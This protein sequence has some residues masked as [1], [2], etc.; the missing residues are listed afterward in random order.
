M[1]NVAAGA[2]PLIFGDLRGYQMVRRIGFSVQVLRELYAEV[3]Q[4]ALVG[5]VRFG[6][7]VTEPWRM[8]AL[9]VSA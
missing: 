8:R 7:Q 9:K 6:G 3:G 1:P 5:R 4:I 2:F